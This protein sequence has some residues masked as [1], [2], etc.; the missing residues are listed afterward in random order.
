MNPAVG[1]D[2]GTTNTVVGVQ[3]D[4]TGP[5]ILDVAQPV[6]ERD[7]LTP[8]DHIKSAVYFESPTSAVVGAF[9]ANRLEA[10][11]SIKSKMGTR[12]RVP[13]PRQPQWLLS[14][15]YVSAH[16]LKAAHQQLRHDFPSWDGSAIITVPASFNTD[17]RSDTL[18]AAR[19]AGF[20]QVRLLDEPTAA[21]YY[22]FD[23]ARQDIDDR[24]RKSVLVFDFGGGTLDV[25]IIVVQPDGEG[26]VIDPIGRSRYN[27]L[28]GDDVDLD[29]AAFL[30]GVW[31]HRQQLTV[32]S[33]PAPLRKRLFAL[34][35]HKASVFKEEVETY[36][37]EGLEP[38]EFHLDEEVRAGQD[39]LNVALT[40]RISRAQ[41][42]EVTS[43]YFDTKSDMNVF[44][45]IS[46]ALE[47]A[48]R[49]VPGFGPQSIDLVLYTGGASRMAAVRAALA[50]HFAPQEAFSISDEEACHTVALGAAACRYDELHR[51]RSV[52]MTARLLESILT[53]SE[54]GSTY[55][56]LVPLVS[57]PSDAYTP[58]DREFRT[59][60]RL[61]TLRVPLFRGT[62]P[63][64]HQLAPMQDLE[65]PLERI[66]EADVPYHL[67]FQMSADKTIQLRAVLRPTGGA[68]IL[69]SAQVDTTG[70]A[71]AEATK[72]PLASVNA[73]QVGR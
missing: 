41:Y 19:L 12:W 71:R 13:H 56:P 62:G 9:A 46:Q 65:L 27:N 43:R 66:V 30:L 36:I 57:E 26:I 18:L 1:I 42:E 50:A 11:R 28:G 47:V 33:L 4:S 29:L 31:Q 6:E 54:D 34:F 45:P 17:Q 61:L 73:R 38:N 72:I 44:R 20:G 21:F 49:I 55:V 25:S 58:V 32:A 40:C 37:A 52:R 23:Q 7:V 2:L 59:Q 51:G 15:P 3:T 14:P 10:Y 35:I 48:A 16:I 64:D 24:R 68:S 60:R 22:Y 70:R 8:V 53:R 69:A 39:R 63:H 5:R 67:E